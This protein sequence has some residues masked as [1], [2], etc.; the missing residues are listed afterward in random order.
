MG[1]EVIFVPCRRLRL[2][3]ICRLQLADLTQNLVKAFVNLLLPSSS[4]LFILWRPGGREE[5][6][7]RCSGI[8]VPP[9]DH[10]LADR[11]ILFRRLSK[12]REG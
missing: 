10:Q 5:L 4:R 6:L 1:R 2:Q 11:W 8:F 9:L 12:F 7:Q 3:H